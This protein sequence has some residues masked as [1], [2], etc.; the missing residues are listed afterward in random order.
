MLN[1]IFAD[2]DCKSEKKPNNPATI[3]GVIVFLDNTILPPPNY[4]INSGM[5]ST[6]IG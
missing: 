5:V 1:A 4:I 3:D 6:P 2:L